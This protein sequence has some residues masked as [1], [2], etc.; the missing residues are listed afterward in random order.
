MNRTQIENYLDAKAFRDYTLLPKSKF[1][2]MLNLDKRRLHLVTP[3]EVDL[4]DAIS[5][6][7]SGKFDGIVIYLRLVDLLAT[8][9]IYDNNGKTIDR[10][11]AV[12]MDRPLFDGCYA[13][14]AMSDKPFHPQG[15]GQ[16]GPSTPG[17]HLGK[18]I[19]FEQL[20]KDCQKL[21][22]QDLE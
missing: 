7:N 20:P 3:S 12:Y 19:K 2:N 15:I 16:H 4:E 5:G 21:V 14:A 13:S 17:R 18:R 9:R 1:D 22:L 8:T 11:T 6:F 10:Y